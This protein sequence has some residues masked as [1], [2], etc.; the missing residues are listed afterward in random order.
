MASVSSARGKLGKAAQYTGAA[1]KG[2]FT[3][4]P[5][6]K[7]DPNDTSRSKREALGDMVNA[8]STNPQTP[9]KTFSTPGRGLV[10]GGQ[11][12]IP[13]FG[14]GVVARGSSSLPPESIIKP[15]KFAADA[16]HVHMQGTNNSYADMFTMHTPSTRPG[17]GSRIPFGPPNS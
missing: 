7:K 1:K 16:P 15:E 12:P 17:M 10:Q 9:D 6:K 4:T 8:F 5:P 13:N 3:K 14:G 11:G 2:Y